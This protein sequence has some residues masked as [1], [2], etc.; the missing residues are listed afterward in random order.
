MRDTSTPRL[1]CSA[2]QDMQRN[3][4][5]VQ[6]AH[7]GPASACRRPSV[8]T[9]RR[10]RRDQ[11]RR[12]TLG[13]A[14]GAG[15]VALAV[16]DRIELLEQALASPG[17]RSTASDIARVRHGCHGCRG[18][19]G[20]GQGRTAARAC[21]IACRRRSARTQ[22]SGRAAIGVECGTAAAAA[23]ATLA[24]HATAAVTKDAS[25]DGRRALYISSSSGS[26]RT[27][28]S[29]SS[30]MSTSRCRPPPSASPASSSSRRI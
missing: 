21:A 5:S 6:D 3:T 16:G 2:A 17:R 25:G 22:A 30:I 27:R 28:I 24:T 11:R 26:T 12:R 1:R 23:A 20:T 18:R 10:L 4:P 15:A 19:R 29:R 9:L 14:V 8:R 13:A 7:R